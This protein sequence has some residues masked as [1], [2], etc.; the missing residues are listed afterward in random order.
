MTFDR[1][2]LV[3]PD[4]TRFEE[5]LI[6]TKGDVVIGDRSLLQFSINTDGRIFI[7]EH[8]ITGGNLNSTNDVRV[9]IFSDIGGNI[10]S[11]GNVY[12]GEKVKVKGKLSLKGDLDVGDSVEIES[13]FEAKGWINIRSPIPTVIYI[14][15]Y[16]LQLLKMGHSEEIERLLEELEQNDG[17]TIPISESFLFIPNNS[18]I[19][20]S[21][22]KIDHNLCIGKECKILGN[23][24]I[25]GNI[26][27][28]DKSDVYGTLKAT[29]DVYCGKNVKIHGNINSNGIVNI[30][31]GTHILGNVSAEKVSLSKTATVQGTLIAKKGVTFIDTLKENATGK[32]K[33]F[34]NNVDVVDEVKEMLE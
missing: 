20:L 11:G 17:K 19:G 25:K 9:D 22:S 4:K 12:L 8:V 21:K 23:Y 26:Y 30:S 3:I 14:F 10:E 1:K 33:R 13:G 32:V 7:G 2:T 27:V 6:T 34:E 29:D 31:D 24:D 28:D 15:I 5:Q 18:I 16:L